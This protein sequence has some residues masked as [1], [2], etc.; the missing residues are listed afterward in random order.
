MWYPPISNWVL[1]SINDPQCV[2]SSIKSVAQTGQPLLCCVCLMHTR[3]AG[4][5][6]TKTS[7]RAERIHRLCGDSSGTWFLCIFDQPTKWATACNKSARWVSYQQSL[8]HLNACTDVTGKVIFNR[9]HFLDNND[10][11]WERLH[12]GDTNSI[13]GGI[14]VKDLC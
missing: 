4:R 8:M 14:A 2:W 11:T 6:T 13:T 9:L 10:Y 3:S 1:R 5:T 7:R 12:H